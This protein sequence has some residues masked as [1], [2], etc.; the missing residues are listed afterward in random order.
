MYLMICTNQRYNRIPTIRNTIHTISRI[1]EHFW[2]ALQY[3]TYCAQHDTNR[4]LYYIH[5]YAP[6]YD[7]GNL[8]LVQSKKVDSSGGGLVAGCCGGQLWWLVAEGG[9]WTLMT[10]AKVGGGGGSIVVVAANG[11][12]WWLMAD[13]MVYL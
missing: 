10:L 11:G 13:G 7:I 9:G 1:H 8:F 12:R 5:N 6:L 2:Y 4:I 3:E